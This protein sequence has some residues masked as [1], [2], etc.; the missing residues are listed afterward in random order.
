MVIPEHNTP[1]QTLVRKEHSEKVR[2]SIQRLPARQRE[3]FVLK[4][5]KGLKISE[6]ARVLDCPEGTVKANLFKA[7]KNLKQYLGEEQ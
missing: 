3:V 1:E 7:I 5:L 2:K 4:H 6:I